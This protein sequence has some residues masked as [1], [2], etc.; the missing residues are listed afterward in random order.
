MLRGGKTLVFALVFAATFPS[1]SFVT[2][3]R[4]IP[5][6]SLVRPC[7]ANENAVGTSSEVIRLFADERPTFSWC[8]AVDVPWL[9]NAEIL[10]FH[11]AIHIDYSSV[12]TIVKATSESP[13]RLICGRRRRNGLNAVPEPAKQPLCDV[14][15]H[16]E[17]IIHDLADNQPYCDDY[18]LRYILG[19]QRP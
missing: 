2:A 4:A 9:P 8:E 13:V 11:T 12:C 15:K 7:T 19:D 16:G 6:S 14:M 17:I 3:Q 5:S 10:R 18:P 1:T